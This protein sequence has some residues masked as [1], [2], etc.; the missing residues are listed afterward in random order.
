LSGE[1]TNGRENKGK[2][3][4]EIN[5]RFRVSIWTHRKKLGMGR[6]FGKED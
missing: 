4:R 2:K 3:E 5:Q 6:N 1:K